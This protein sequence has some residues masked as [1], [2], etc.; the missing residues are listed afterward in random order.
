[1]GHIYLYTGN[2][3]GKTT[4]ALGLALRSIGHGHRVKIL[5]FMKWWKN[6][7]EYKF[8]YPNYQIQLMGRKEWTGKGN[9]N[10]EDVY[11]A[12]MA[13]YGATTCRN[14]DLLILD[15]LNLAVA[16]GLLKADAVVKAL[17]EIQSNSPNMDI[18]IT[19]RHAPKALIDRSDFVNRITTIKM[20][21]Q[22][23]CKEGIQY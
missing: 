11:M 20:P 17:D 8:R 14:I 15:E 6:T 19:G 9:L 21:K 4:N 3:A 7:G 18:V 2:G 22:I 16:W 10:K 12:E 1:M 5:Q 13:L 23:I